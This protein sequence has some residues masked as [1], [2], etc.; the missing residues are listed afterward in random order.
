M[1]EA[2]SGLFGRTLNFNQMAAAVGKLNRW[3]EDTGVL[4][5]VRRRRRA[6]L[7][8]P[9]CCCRGRASI[10]GDR[11]AGPGPFV[12]WPCCAGGGGRLTSTPPNRSVSISISPPCSTPHTSPA[13]QV[14]DV[15]TRSAS[16]SLIPL[17]NTPTP[18]HHHD[19][20]PRSPHQVVDV[21]TSSAVAEVKVSEAQVARI[22]LR[23]IDRQTNEVGGCC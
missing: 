6:V 15:D 13:P 9:R 20:P 3:Y 8:V 22:I 10:R 11:G 16:P 18:P 5:Q 4:G 2:F 23:Y 21:D 19:P 14:E 17:T 7:M 1:E 12:R